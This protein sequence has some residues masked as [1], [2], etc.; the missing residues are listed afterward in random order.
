MA[1]PSN[2][3]TNLKVY[4]IPGVGVEVHAVFH[5]ANGV[6]ATYARFQVSTDPNF[7]TTVYD[8]GQVSITPIADGTEGV[9]VFAFIPSSAGTYYY[10]LCFW[11]NTNKNQTNLT[12]WNG[13]TVGIGTAHTLTI[14]PDGDSTV[15]LSIYPTSPTTHYDKVDEA[16]Q[17]GNTDYVYASYPDNKKDIFTFQ[18]TSLYGYLVNIILRA[19]IWCY[20]GFYDAYLIVN[21]IQGNALGDSGGDYALY[22]WTHTT[23]PATGLPWTW[24]EI[25]SILAGV[26][27]YVSLNS[28]A[29]TRCTQI[30]IDVNYNDWTLTFT[31]PGDNILTVGFPTVSDIQVSNNKEHYTFTATVQD[32]YSKTP[33]ASLKVSNNSVLMDYISRTGSGPYTYTFQKDM[34]LEKG[35][36]EYWVEVGNVWTLLIGDIRFLYVDYTFSR[37]PKVEVF[38]NNEKI[39]A[40]NILI[41]DNVLPDVPEISFET[42]EDLPI[43]PLTTKLYLKTLRQYVFDITS[44]SKTA[45]GWHIEG[46]EKAKRD[47]EQTVSSDFAV[48]LSKDLLQ[49]LLRNYVLQGTLDEYIYLQSFNDETIESIVRKILILNY[50]IGYLRNSKMYV[51]DL[52]NVQ[53]LFRI[54]KIDAQIGYSEDPTAI[55]NKVHEFYTIKNFPVPISSLTNY[56]AV[57]WGGTASNVLQTANGILPSSGNPYCLKGTGTIYRTVSFLWSNFDQLKLNWSPDTATTLEIRLETDASNYRKYTRSFSGQKNAGFTLTSSLSTDIVTKTISFGTYQ[58]Y[59]H[60][61]E[62]SLTQFARVKIDLKLAGVLVISSDWMTP[63][64]NKFAYIFNNILCD[65]IVLSFTSLYPVGTSY[66]VIC[67]Y[68]GI[69]Q[70]MQAF[71]SYGSSFINSWVSQFNAPTVYIPPGTPPGTVYTVPLGAI[72][73]AGSGQYDINQPYQPNGVVYQIVNGQLVAVITTQAGDEG[74]TQ[75]GRLPVTA[76]V[77]SYV[78][79]GEWVWTYANYAWSSTFNLFDEMTIPFS[80]FTVVGTPTDQINT[81][82]LIATGDNYHDNLYVAQSNPIAQYVETTNPA[83]ILEYGERFQRR[84]TDGW[85]AKD[86]ATKFAEAF[87]DYYGDSAVSYSK[88][89][90]LLTDIDI[91]DMVA[92]DDSKILPVYK[93]AYDLDAGQKT[94]FIGRS[95]TD[96]LEFLKETS[97]K[98]E[99]VEKTIL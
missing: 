44:K 12:V 9:M 13:A 47:I 83:S 6:N 25:N 33:L 67:N 30:Y 17:N 1:N 52:S 90:S 23:N 50:S 82:R 37:P 99:A 11:D 77:Q 89:I 93:I 40:W 85:S 88:Q 54:A 86:S 26:R 7:G 65:S 71:Q 69:E 2:S 62:G 64:Q 57:N 95:T 79:S 91:G 41:T 15:E 80:Q 34:I 48:I 45:E 49:S 84:T 19:Y 21:G 76:A 78:P 63:W 28:P 3:P 51:F 56:D 32:T 4:P 75:F 31:P 36:Y 27:G 66:G 53:T 42:D 29:Q 39:K 81:I 38:V 87:V 5:Q 16:S 8:S 43:V 35:N 46:K 73:P 60:T 18:D 55:C 70:Y 68:V 24:E 10:R 58:K 14:R 92:C 98:I 22:S 96:T 72:P 94:I 61:I 20:P 59:I 74:L 97:R